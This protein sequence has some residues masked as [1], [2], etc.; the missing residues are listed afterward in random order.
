MAQYGDGEYPFYKLI[1]CLF[2]QYYTNDKGFFVEMQRKEDNGISDGTVIIFDPR[3][4]EAVEPCL[5]LQGDFEKRE[6]KDFFYATNC[7]I[8]AK[9]AHSNNG[10]ADSWITILEQLKKYHI[11]AQSNTNAFSVATRGF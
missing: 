1:N 3:S 11:N 2:C 5:G 10:R 7:Y 8:E 4:K 9:R 6:K